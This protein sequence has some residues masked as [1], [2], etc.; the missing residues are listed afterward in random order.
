MRGDLGTLGVILGATLGGVREMSLLFKLKN[1]I[2]EKHGGSMTLGRQIIF[3]GLSLKI[4]LIM[5]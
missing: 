2:L 5:I 4:K 3:R 1:I